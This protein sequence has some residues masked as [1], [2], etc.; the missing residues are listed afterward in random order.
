MLLFRAEENITEWSRIQK[1]PRGQ[2]LTLDQVWELSRSW[3]ADRLSTDY[4]GRTADQVERIFRGVGLSN[5]F[6]QL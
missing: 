5:S 3:Y 2:L 4:A 1:M 6:W